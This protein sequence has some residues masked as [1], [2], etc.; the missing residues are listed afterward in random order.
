MHE[1][2]SLIFL[3]FFLFFF[4]SPNLLLSEQYFNEA[5]RGGKKMQLLRPV[6]CSQIPEGKIIYRLKPLLFSVS[7]QSK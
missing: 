1:N 6:D 5:F 2:T 4:I 3:I 7:L